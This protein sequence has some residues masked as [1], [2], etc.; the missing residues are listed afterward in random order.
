MA[1]DGWSLCAKVSWFTGNQYQPS[2]VYRYLF[3]PIGIPAPVVPAASSSNTGPGGGGGGGGGSYTPMTS[4]TPVV[5]DMQVIPQVG[6]PV[7]VS[8]L[9]STVVYPTQ[10]STVMSVGVETLSVDPKYTDGTRVKVYR[11]LL[12]GRKRL[13]GS[14]IVEKGSVKIAYK[15]SGKYSIKF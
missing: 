11:D 10:F 1:A 5:V 7:M 4:T 15:K 14:V 9:G 6:V 3:G 13:V 12:N 2:N 8:V